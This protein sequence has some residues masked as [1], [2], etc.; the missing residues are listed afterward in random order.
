MENQFSK[1]YITDEQYN[2]LFQTI[3]TIFASSTKTSETIVDQQN[4]PH[5]P[6]VLLILRGLPGTG[7]SSLGKKIA[8]AFNGVQFESDK[9]FTIAGD[10]H[11]DPTLCGLSHELTQ[12]EARQAMAHHLPLVVIS[13]TATR[14]WEYQVY[15]EAGRQFGY[16]I[17]IFDLFQHLLTSLSLMTPTTSSGTRNDKK[18]EKEEER[19][20]AYFQY[21]ASSNIHDVPPETIVEMARRYEFSP[22]L[23]TVEE[24]RES[25]DNSL[26]GDGSIKRRRL[27]ENKYIAVY[28]SGYFLALDI[29]PADRSG[30]DH[31]VLFLAC[32][33]ACH[34]LAL[35]F[36]LPSAYQM[37]R[38]VVQRNLKSS[39]RGGRSSVSV[40]GWA[41]YHLT[42]LPPTDYTKVKEKGQ[43]DS[44]VEALQTLRL[45]SLLDNYL[46]LQADPSSETFASAWEVV[47]SQMAML[48]GEIVQ[49]EGSTI[50]PARLTEEIAALLDADQQS[51]TFYLLLDRSHGL[52]AELHALRQRFLQELEEEEDQMA[53]EWLPHITLAFTR[54][55]LHE[56]DRLSGLEAFQMIRNKLLG[57]SP[58]SL[59]QADRA[60]ESERSMIVSNLDIDGT[61]SLCMELALHSETQLSFSTSYGFHVADVRIRRGPFGDDATYKTHPI[62]LQLLP[63]GLVFLQSQTRVVSNGYRPIWRGLHSLPK[64]FGKEGM[65]DDGAGLSSLELNLRLHDYLSQADKLV[66]M[67]KVNGRAAS[68]RFFQQQQQQQQ[69]QDNEY[70]VIIG[71]K[72]AHTIGRLD[73]SRQRIL[74]EECYYQDLKASAEEVQDE[75]S[76]SGD[77]RNALI[78]SNTQALEKSLR[79][80]NLLELIQWLDGRTL[81][82]EVLDPEDMHLVAIDSLQWVFLCLSDFADRLARRPSSEGLLETLNTANHF[83][84]DLP[85]LDIVELSVAAGCLNKKEVVISHAQDIA[86][87]I[88]PSEGKVLYLIDRAGCVLERIKYKTWWYVYRRAIRQLACK[89]LTR[90]NDQPQSSSRDSS[91]R[92]TQQ[93][94]EATQKKLQEQLIQ[95]QKIVENMGK[96]RGKESDIGFQNKLQGLKDKVKDLEIRLG[97][98]SQYNEEEVRVVRARRLES[99]LLEL[100]NEV[101]RRWIQKFSFMCEDLGGGEVYTA[102]VAEAIDHALAFLR[103]LQSELLVNEKATIKTFRRYYPVMWESFLLA[104][105]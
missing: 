28:D 56:V 45:D 71:T 92:S 64:F 60:S 66:I 88:L 72:L 2:E 78:L 104:K 18:E 70:Y 76:S 41:R 81:N 101:K 32:L 19:R 12:A 79:W 23:I 52:L 95:L 27:G 14:H 1:I 57:D 11:F 87:E 46:G 10:Y 35:L 53:A 98:E 49:Q 67:E 105:R 89:L 73:F 8:E 29:L 16:T 39:T 50:A 31:N 80:E 96:A 94:Q 74:L 22:Q 17:V 65:E 33:Y 93:A 54:N 68:C 6:T 100:E 15:V 77:Y 103:Y 84:N 26:S 90:W 7:K 99:V 47:L 85:L 38:K 102:K 30:R 86:K 83:M 69:Q 37:I 97:K 63:R 13:N 34:Y 24:T 42:V 36:D 62:L 55:D 5:P 40:A 9:N 43:L 58:V 91:R 51:T 82:G 48:Q 21:L 3:H 25:V 75:S 61:R 59:F 20:Q 44:F 4:E